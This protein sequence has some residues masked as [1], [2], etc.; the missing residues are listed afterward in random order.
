[1]TKFLGKIDDLILKLEE[2]HTFGDNEKAKLVF[3]ELRL[4]SSYIKEQGA[5]DNVLLD[6]SLARGLDYYTGM[7]FEVVI[8]G[9]NVGSLGGGK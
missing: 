8:S 6:L 9:F 5:Y 3:E 7:I 1:M 4:L 2:E